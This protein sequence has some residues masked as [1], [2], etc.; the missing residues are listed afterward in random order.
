MPEPQTR[1]TKQ[2]DAIESAIE[3]ADRPLS[4]QEILDLGRESVPSMSL[5]TV[6]RTVKALV[7]EGLARPVEL[8][9][10]PPRYEPHGKAHHHHFHCVICD[11]AFDLPGCPISLKG[12]VPPGFEVEGHDLTLTGR[13]PDCSGPK[14]RSQAKK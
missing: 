3:A 5:A 11:R 6:Y 1:R 9:G 2:R 12:F 4:P 10:E 8:P 13:C 14:A 7:D